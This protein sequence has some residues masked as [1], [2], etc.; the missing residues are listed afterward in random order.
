MTLCAP[1]VRG[2][3]GDAATTRD[4]QALIV[5]AATVGALARSLGS[6]VV[7]PVPE[8]LALWDQND[9]LR[10]AVIKAIYSFVSLSDYDRD[11]EWN[12]T[13]LAV[14]DEYQAA[15]LKNLGVYVANIRYFRET[16]APAGV[17]SGAMANGG[18]AAAIAADT[19]STIKVL[20]LMKAM[21]NAMSFFMAEPGRNWIDD[22][23]DGLGEMA[24][25]VKDLGVAL[26]KLAGAVGH[27]AAGLVGIL[28]WI[29]RHA[30]P[31]AAVGG[32]GYLATR[33]SKPARRKSAA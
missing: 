14:R 6:A 26:L 28:G 2:A 32:V 29:A 23:G 12:E 8:T 24:T 11:R 17:T 19:Q 1:C 16:L 4:L 22:V 10:Q 9:R 15:K 13:W 25:G 3:L 21:K 31:L 20:K 5:Q 7:L 18:F 30:V 33:E 27:G